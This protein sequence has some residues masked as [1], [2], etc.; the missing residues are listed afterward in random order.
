MASIVKDEELRSFDVPEVARHAGG[1]TIY[2]I[3]LQVTPKE[4]TEN[5]YQV[6]RRASRAEDVHRTIFTRTRVETIVSLR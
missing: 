1:Y 4:I 5:S 3:I 2:K 6:K